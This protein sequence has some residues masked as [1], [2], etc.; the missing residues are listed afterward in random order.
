[1]GEVLVVE[2]CPDTRRLIERALGS[3]FALRTCEGLAEA[4]A[5]LAESTPDLVILDIGLPDGD[6]M[7]L[8]SELR[9]VESTRAI[10]VI[11]L[12]ARNAVD[13]KVTA[14]GLGANDF[15]EKPFNAAELSARVAAH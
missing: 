1:M 7:V 9:S 10:P 2:D 3:Q 11:F 6:G 12:S 4:R 5:A 15:V 14:F 8:C 13:T